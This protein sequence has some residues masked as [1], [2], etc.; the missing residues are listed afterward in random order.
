[1]H[2]IIFDEF[3]SIARKR[4]MEDNTSSTVGSQI[5]NQ[6]LVKMDGVEELNNILII[7]LTN[8]KDIIDPALIRPGRFEIT[9]E[10]KLPNSFRPAELTYSLPQETK[11]NYSH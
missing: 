11:K 7:A 5:V 9:L 10:V 2:V 4:S 3:D 8:R 1:M 6:L